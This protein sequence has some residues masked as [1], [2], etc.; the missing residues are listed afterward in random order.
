MYYN[1]DEKDCYRNLAIAIITQAVIDINYTNDIDAINFLN[2]DW[3]W[4]I[5]GLANMDISGKE[6]LTILERI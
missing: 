2:S 1:K 4:C 3:Y 5:A 6:M